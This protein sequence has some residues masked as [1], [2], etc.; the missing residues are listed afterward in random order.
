MNSY[1]LS[2][3]KDTTTINPKIVRTKNN[4]LIMLS[5]CDTCN[6]KK[7]KFIK[8]TRSERIIK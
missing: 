4:R 3:K 1:C 5:K 7:S 8:G 2:C 6:N